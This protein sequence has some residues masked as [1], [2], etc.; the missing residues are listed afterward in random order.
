MRSKKKSCRTLNILRYAFLTEEDQII[1]T[2]LYGNIR[3]YEKLT[4][5][6][7]HIF[8]LDHTT[9]CGF[10]PAYYQQI[11]YFFTVSF[12]LHLAKAEYVIPALE[13]LESVAPIG[14]PVKVIPVLPATLV[15]RVVL[16]AAGEGHHKNKLIDRGSRV[17]IPNLQGP[18]CFMYVSDG[19][20][21]FSNTEEGFL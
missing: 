8:K 18:E 11:N 13:D 12:K 3:C 9:K 6:I 7:S 5:L 4:S 10:F 16:E 15:M 1:L 14:L 17:F 21:L 2:T 19:F 20:V